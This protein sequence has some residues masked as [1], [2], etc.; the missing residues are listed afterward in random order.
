MP[1]KWGIYGPEKHRRKW[2]VRVCPP[3][4]PG[5]SRGFDTREAAQAYREQVET[6]LSNRDAQH[7]AACLFAEAEAALT[8]AR[9]VEGKQKTVSEAIEH[10]ELYL[11]DTRGLRAASVITAIYRVR[12]LLRPLVSVNVARVTSTAAAEAYKERA[13][14]G[15]SPATHRGELKEVRRLW[16]WL[17]TKRWV[18]ANPWSAVE[19]KGK[20]P[21]GKA[22]LRDHEVERVERLAL[23]MARGKGVGTDH[24]VENRRTGPLAV[25]VALYLGPRPLEVVNLTVRDVGNVLYVDGTKTSNAKRRVRMP[26]VLA[27]LLH[28]HAAACQ[29]RG[30]ERLFPHS[31]DW[32]R[33]WVKR[34]CRLAGVPEVCAQ[35]LRGL[36]A[37]LATEAGET[38]LAVARQLGHG[39]PTVTY[40]HYI[41]HEAAEA[42]RIRATLSELGVAKMGRENDRFLDPQGVP[43]TPDD[44]QT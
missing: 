14:A 4:G 8:E 24:W 7:R 29:E 33:G 34:L 1:N 28:Q 19:P 13:D 35:S 3:D 42:A 10:Y 38:G 12:G 32:L 30:Q 41:T 15:V 25:L 27:T 39:S 17:V 5:R 6:E 44:A 26:P 36:H 11:R 16:R 18:V 21:K 20:V 31:R 9:A 23:D 40:D 37:T 22:Q 2:R 43:D